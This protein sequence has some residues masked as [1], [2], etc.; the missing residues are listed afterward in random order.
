[1]DIAIVTG[2]ASSLGLAIS[3][4]LLGLGMRVYGLG[5]DYS[6]CPLQNVDF[7]PVN[8]DL[9]DPNQVIDQTCRIMARE[10]GVCLIVNNARYFAREAF[11]RQ[12]PAE[13]DRAVRINLLCPL[14]LVR[15]AMPGL[16]RLQ[17]L[18]VNL[19]TSAQDGGRGGTVGAACAGGLRWAADALFLELRDLGVRVSTIY[20][21]AN[22]W[23]PEDNPPPKG[24]HPESVI[25]PQAVAEAIAG[26]VLNRSGNVITELVVRPAR[27]RETGIEPVCHLPYPEPKPIPYTV[28]RE[29]IE[30]ED[31]LEREAHEQRDRKQKK[32][33][34]ASQEQP[35]EPAPR[36]PP[37]APPRRG[38][39]PAPAP[40]RSPP[41]RTGQPEPEGGATPAPAADDK[42]AAPAADDKAAAPARRR[43][44]RRGR[45]QAAK[46]AGDGRQPP[47]PAA[48]P[49]A[50]PE[51]AGADKSGNSDGSVKSDTHAVPAKKAARKRPRRN[52]GPG[53]PKTDEI[54]PQAQD[55]R[56]QVED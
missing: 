51:L 35:P 16:V 2:A 7:I 14:L 43:R 40:R 32:P 45:G 46:A 36:R 54:R 4:R 24:A 50:K 34:P 27:T 11:V 13:I 41:A 37:P 55:R 21:E 23:R 52:T 29:W 12:E 10:G 3:R 30:A 1:M 26:L 22:R 42:A 49:A 25:D 20:P 44:G 18:I 6:Q 48:K 19:G 31:L 38:S 28:P 56:G 17:G 8:C 53:K 15:C 47:A 39:P 33:A 9:A 5:G